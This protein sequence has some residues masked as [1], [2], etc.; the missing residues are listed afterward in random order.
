[1]AALDQLRHL[2]EEEGEQERA[3]VAAVHIGVG[4]DDDL[5]VAQ[6]IDV[7][8]VAT[9]AGAERRYQ[10]P[11][12]L[13]RQHLVEARPLDIQDFAAQRPDRLVLA[14]PPLLGR[15]A[16]RVALDD[17]ELGLRRI[18]FLAVRPLAGQRGGVER[19]LADRKEHTSELQSLMRNTYAVFCLKKQQTE[20]TTDDHDADN[21]D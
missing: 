11:D 9:D 15:A 18:A 1:M 21:H 17:E 8:L 10:S 3:D 7:E 13:R 5:V 14:V 2:P 20:K 19:A 6:L 4:H 16:G 12:L